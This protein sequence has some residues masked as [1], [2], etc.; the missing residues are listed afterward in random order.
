VELEAFVQ[1]IF[2]SSD[3][4]QTPPTRRYPA[5][6][7]VHPLYNH[8][9]WSNWSS[10]PPS[11]PAIVSRH[12]IFPCEYVWSE[13]GSFVHTLALQS[14]IYAVNPAAK[15]RYVFHVH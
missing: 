6:T 2:Q 11:V 3:T 10:L 13:A 1:R 15:G 4:S 12:C 14:Y 8:A 5:R 9:V 7:A